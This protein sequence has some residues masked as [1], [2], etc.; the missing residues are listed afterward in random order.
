MASAWVDKSSTSSI[1][2]LAPGISAGVTCLGNKWFI[3]VVGT[4]ND[5]AYKSLEIAKEEAHIRLRQKL[6]DAM[7][8]LDSVPILR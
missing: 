7:S 5:I 2:N 8:A 1:L 4:K 6:V 3:N